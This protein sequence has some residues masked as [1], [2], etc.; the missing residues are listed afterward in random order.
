MGQEARAVE[1]PRL[2]D[3]PAGHRD[4]GP[5]ECGDGSAAGPAEGPDHQG[6]RRLLGDAVVPSAA[7]GAGGDERPVERVATGGSQRHVE[8]APVVKDPK[9]G[10][11]IPGPHPEGGHPPTAVV[12]EDLQV[13]QGA[14]TCDEA[15]K[16]RSG[17]GLA[18]ER[19]PEVEVAVPQRGRRV[20]QLL[21]PED[22]DVVRRLHPAAGRR[23]PG[24]GRD[25]V[26]D[27]QGALR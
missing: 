3:V 2:G 11:G 15:G 23:G 7:V 20:G 12:D 17:A 13:E 25:V 19:V 9:R 24:A 8:D 10:A 1:V 16:Q 26:P 27:R 22:V 18:L 6:A 14:T 21:E 4:A 5:L